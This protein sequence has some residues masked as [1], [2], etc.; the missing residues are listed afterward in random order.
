MRTVCAASGN[1]ASASRIPSSGRMASLLICETSVDRWSRGC[2]RAIAMAL[3][4][5]ALLLGL[6]AFAVCAQDYPRRPVRLIVPFPPS[7]GNDSVARA[8]AQ[9]LSASPGQP[10]VVDNRAGPGGAIGAELA[11][12]APADG[13][14]LFLGGVGSHV[15]N[16]NLH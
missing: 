10:F 15:V 8:V 4:N 6:V 7:G 5:L 14:T 13:Y 11:A 2:H 16:P 3:R 12:R 9:Q 1:A